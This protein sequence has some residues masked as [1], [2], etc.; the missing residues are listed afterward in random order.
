[1]KKNL[2]QLATRWM[3]LLFAASLVIT[4][5]DLILLAEG[6]ATSESEQSQVVESLEGGKSGGEA[7]AGE[8]TEVTNT[9]GSSE[10]QAEG[11]PEGEQDGQVGYEEDKKLKDVEDSNNLPLE[12]SDGNTAGD[13][14]L[15]DN[16][17]GA[18]K[19][20]EST[21]GNNETLD[22]SSNN[23]TGNSISENDLS[24]ND[25][26]ANDI[27]ADID[28]DALQKEI[29]ALS[30]LDEMEANYK[31]LKTE[32]ERN[33]YINE[34]YMAFGEIIDE[35]YNYELIDESNSEELALIDDVKDRLDVT[36]LNDLMLYFNGAITFATDPTFELTSVTADAGEGVN[37]KVTA[38]I[39]VTGLADQ[40]SLTYEVLN[41]VNCA[42]N[43]TYDSNSKIYTKGTHSSVTGTVTVAEG[44]ITIEGLKFGDHVA[45]I[46]D[47]TTLFRF[48]TLS[49]SLLNGSFEK[50]DL[51]TS[52]IKGYNQ[53]FETGDAYAWHTTAYNGQVEI[54]ASTRYGTSNAEGTYCA[55]LCGLNEKSSLYQ[56]VKTSNVEVMSWSLK[57][58]SR[59]NGADTMAVVIGPALDISDVDDDYKGYTKSSADADDIFMKIVA[60]LDTPDSSDFNKEQKVTYQGKEYYV[61]LIQSK[62]RALT[63]YSGTYEVPDGQEETVFA[64]VAIGT[65]NSL[66][67]CQNPDAGNLLDA[68]SFSKYSAPVVTYEGIVASSNVG[69][70]NES[71]TVSL[72]VKNDPGTLTYEVTNRQ[73][74]HSAQTNH[75]HNCIHTNVT[76][77]VDSTSITGL[78]Y[79]DHVTVKQDET[80]LCQFKVLA[81][82]LLNGGFETSTVDSNSCA[83]TIR[84][85][86][87]TYGLYAWHTT[88]SDLN[89]ELRTDT[90]HTGEHC[91]ELNA[92]EF[93]SLYQ[94]INAEPGK[95][96]N[97]SVQHAGRAGTD[98]M[99]I[100]V[101]PALK[102]GTEY[103]KTSSQETEKDFFAKIVAAAEA[104]NA[105]N[106]L[107]VGKTYYVNYEENVY[108]VV[109]ARDALTAWRTYSGSYTVPSGVSEV[110]FGFSAISSSG[111]SKL[112]GNL[113]DEV[114]FGAYVKPAVSGVTVGSASGSGL[115][116]S[117]TATLTTSDYAS[118]E[119]LTYEVTNRQVAGDGTHTHSAN[120]KHDNVTGTVDNSTKQITG[121]KYGDHV[122]VKYNGEIIYQ[123]K[124]LSDKLLNGSLE[125]NSYTYA[126]NT[127]YT[128][129]RTGEHVYAWHTTA[130]DS[131]IE[132]WTENV[133]KTIENTIPDGKYIS[134]LAAYETSSLYQ[135]IKAT[136]GDKLSW[137]VA[138][139][140]R[141]G[142]DEMAIVVGP[143]KA[144]SEDG[145]D[146]YRK[147]SS[148]ETDFFASIVAK[149]KKE[150][151]TLETGE[152][153]YT[154]YDGVE[155]QV[156]VAQDG[157]N[158]W[159]RY[160]GTY[161]VP[162]GVTEVV[163]GFS[164]ISSSNNH[165]MDGNLI[166]AVSFGIYSEP[167]VDTK[168]LALQVIKEQTEGSDTLDEAITATLS[169][170]DYPE[171]GDL[172]YEVVNRQEDGCT[173]YHSQNC[174]KT[175]ANISGTVTKNTDETISIPNLKY[176]DHV[177]IKYG[178]ETIA[179]FKVLSDK[180]L[181]GDFE[182]ATFNASSNKTIG[183]CCGEL[184]TGDRVYAWH[185]TASDL[186]MELRYDDA[187]VGKNNA[188]LNAYEFAS[189][190]QEIEATAD[191]VLD[192]SVSHAGR[193]GT[194][195]MA[196]VVGPA[197]KAGT[198]YT[199]STADE[200]DFFAQIVQTAK[201]ANN[202]TLNVGRT[203]KV[204]Y[205]GSVYQVVVATDTQGNWKTYS[206]SYTVPTGVN[207]V[208]FGFSAISSHD[209]N[210]IEGNLIDNVSLGVST[211]VKY[212][213]S[214]VNTTAS[215]N[216][217]YNNEN[218]SVD[219][220]M[221]NYI[222]GDLKY[223]VTN[224]KGSANSE[225]G[226]SLTLAD[227]DN[228]KK[229][230][231]SDLKYGDN[232]AVTDANGNV[233]FNFKVL[234]KELLN[235]SFEINDKTT[236]TEGSKV[237]SEI[238]TG[239]N[240]YAWHTTAS[241]GNMKLA[242]TGNDSVDAND[243]NYYAG[244]TAVEKA[245]L[246]QEI[247]TSGDNKSIAWSFA[248]AGKDA[249]AQMAIVI[250]PALD[251]S[252]SYTK[253]SSNSNDMFMDIAK[254]AV[255]GGTNTNQTYT[256][257]YNGNTYYVLFTDSEKD[258]K[259]YS[260][261]YT[262]PANQDETVVA[263]VPMYNTVNFVD[264]VSFGESELTTSY[265]VSGNDLIIK[266]DGVD[267]DKTN[268]KYAV[269]DKDG[270]VV[271]KGISAVKKDG[272]EF[273]D[274]D[275]NGWFDKGDDTSNES[276]TFT[277]TNANNGPYTVVKTTAAT[278]KTET[279]TK[280]GKTNV[281]TLS[282]EGGITWYSDEN[283]T[284]GKEITG[285]AGE[286]LDINDE[287][288]EKTVYFKVDGGT[289]LS[290]ISS[291]VK[292]NNSEIMY[293]QIEKH[294]DAQGNVYYSVT[295]KVPKNDTSTTLKV[296]Q[297]TDSGDAIKVDEDGTVKKNNIPWAS[298]V[299]EIIVTDDSTSAKCDT[300][301]V[302]NS[303]LTDR[304][305]I[306]DDDLTIYAEGGKVEIVFEAEKVYNVSNTTQAR[307]NAVLS[308]EYE[309]T[310]DME[311]YKEGQYLDIRIFKNV[312]DKNETLV[313]EMS[314][315][316]NGKIS[317]LN[318]M[319]KITINLKN[320]M[321]N[322]INMDPS[323]ERTY[324]VIRI[325]TNSK[326]KT[327]VTGLETT[328]DDDSKTITFYSD[329]FSDYV[330]LY[331]DTE[332][333]K[334]NSGNSGSSGSSGSSDDSDDSGSS[335]I[336]TVKD[337][338]STAVATITTNVKNT[339]GK[340]KASAKT[341]D[342]T[343]EI[344]KDT[345]GT[346]SGN[347]EG[348]D[349]DK[350]SD[351][352]TD[353]DKTTDADKT[354]DSE[355][356]SGTGSEDGTDLI[357]GNPDAEDGNG[358]DSWA[359][360]NLLAML[361]TA[362]I[363]IARLPKALKD[364]S[365]LKLAGLVPMIIAIVLFFITEDL[366]GSLGF[367]D[368]WTIVMILLLAIEAAITLIKGKE[369]RESK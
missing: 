25:I 355:A 224:R 88:A 22:S 300:S 70:L 208:V 179:N 86:E 44:K 135:E 124:V 129:G 204:T 326:N 233:Q 272:S 367:I 61:Y 48:K 31:A 84:T 134:E 266:I 296:V 332:S 333:T 101:G 156:T 319:I 155:Y 305:N 143:A 96:L 6:D 267:T 287:T 302:L 231:I 295:F 307:V 284:S 344:K 343:E 53:F 80:V 19:N 76:G 148:T 162:R 265:E 358:S 103:T 74:A 52:S 253:A 230:T 113:I 29:D 9:E 365:Y 239:T 115:S 317:E 261:L 56:E 189:L 37:Q 77:T 299:G 235:G 339:F 336:D 90:G 34:V 247:D 126:K 225:I 303:L 138:H 181:N 320:G 369:G 133:N 286:M 79:G 167:T 30:T 306:T 38:T 282:D 46:K 184:R 188:E 250:G 191:E 277:L 10:E 342:A 81:D 279:A 62:T 116:E 219:V 114:S 130:S 301:E 119:V 278:P 174:A 363:A 242:Y 207:E 280:I 132:L 59:T 362:V 27:Y 187:R 201:D 118:N 316:T 255:G 35:L 202:G 180:L 210:N 347:T 33:A 359:L 325:H 100:V 198:E 83:D 152:T 251:A 356:E 195:T 324:Q 109:V 331:K 65:N 318:D 13:N 87:S 141:A 322:L 348:T 215:Q 314:G 234:S 111:G 209:N 112:E 243:E 145:K 271:T 270:K 252:E 304:D 366:S 122:A 246:Y 350:D 334:N 345:E 216:Q 93:S 104:A 99:A 260:G 313:T 154:E 171:F 229:A 264:A 292:S 258:W 57:H 45:I 172:T 227:A 166:D 315:A 169:V 321:S 211:K 259:A 368:G 291:Y 232:V 15:S 36:K 21:S 309:D 75:D 308:G 222:S 182:T 67:E 248:H 173:G 196:I 14:S 158:S 341:V 337:T 142:V 327:S 275:S 66:T 257:D 273:T 213:S 150:N 16:N 157:K 220:V 68:I 23:V 165:L 121:L 340:K 128:S 102:T 329:K 178:D 139:C 241:D 312:Y 105:N 276:I 85:G 194:D 197:L 28:F 175:H 151:G 146:E 262:V 63:S 349:T 328:Y 125:I 82:K 55:E 221:S 69:T 192:W 281:I 91:A 5:V 360:L 290:V 338:V 106:T 236:V 92:W 117:I 1:M 364:K 4:N 131:N 3:A 199:K 140:G 200:K 41:R 8:I 32:D 283:C 346:V 161:T 136:P 186:N 310:M 149:A 352:T 361:A 311:G 40:T 20:S 335:V 60:K 26:S 263:Y 274:T 17:D 170:S 183:S 11:T 127:A 64:F 228:N 323:K 206:G 288:G 97:W 95:V 39:T 89:I 71:L 223:V 289:D 185:T 268:T 18:E 294:K 163:F 297:G 78:K 218:L 244:L 120:C 240:L 7:P 238:K 51:T 123:F 43:D 160:T 98:T 58:A 269:L 237:S 159:K 42:H 214:E 137:G 177:A 144:L 168:T 353:I 351:K 110:V 205:N 176:G 94:E 293:T 164:A 193:K 2:K 49:D 107:E 254:K 153:Y 256:V 24:T 357:S 12:N 285:F 298:K 249:N 354:T 203:Y 217:G 190:Y 147:T 50:G 47:G 73:N 212:V 226:G 245:S 72:N 108:Q 54:A 330:I